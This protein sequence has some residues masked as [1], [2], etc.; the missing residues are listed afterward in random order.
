MA[1]HMIKA[2]NDTE[3]LLLSITKVCETPFE[4]THTRSQE[5]LHFKPTRPGKLSLLNHP[6]Q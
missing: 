2:K 3:D 5:T 6:Y 4:Q 1:V